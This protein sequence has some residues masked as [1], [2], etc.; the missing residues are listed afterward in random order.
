MSL[1][2]A[3]LGGKTA[4]LTTLTHSKYVCCFHLNNVNGCENSRW[5]TDMSP[6]MT[7]LLSMLKHSVVAD[8]CRVQLNR[9][10]AT[11][12]SPDVAVTSQLVLGMT[13]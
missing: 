13:L 5:Y 1:K 9:A 7:S 4:Q 2:A 11:S 3:Q 8:T 10:N 6:W 12:P